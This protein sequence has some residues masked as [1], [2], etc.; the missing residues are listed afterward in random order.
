MNARPLLS[1]LALTATFAACA[2]AGRSGPPA[3]YARTAT[4]GYASPT[5]AQAPQAYGRTASAEVT[6][7]STGG[8][9]DAPA[10]PSES[11]G[12]AV[13]V[14]AEARPGLATE[15]GETRYSSMSYAPFVRASSMPYD[16]AAIH[17]N[18]A[19]LAA[20]QAMMH[21]A[22]PV[23][24]R[25]MYRDGVRVSLRDEGGGALP[26]YY[27]GDSVYVLGNAGQ[28]YTILIENMTSARFETVVSVD[29]L[30]VITGRAAATGSRGYI[31]QAHGRIEVE[32]FRQ[33][34]DEVATFRFGSVG[35]SYAAQT[36]DARNVGVIG[37]ALFA[38]RGA[39]LDLEQ[40]E[41]RLR[42]QANPFPG[43]FAAPPPRQ[44]Y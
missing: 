12:S 42:E 35:D 16:M 30:D 3:V 15:W 41:L 18:D 5:S 25:G 23:Q 33:N 44:Y 39:T 36:G 37:V 4:G 29:G 28:R 19:R 22:R 13:P 17:Y 32:G 14:P 6:T 24:Y 43:G 1:L 21:A 11:S 20:M 10:A 2:S 8:D 27:S 34:H 40:N 9:Y 26:G 38:E 31:L 7:S